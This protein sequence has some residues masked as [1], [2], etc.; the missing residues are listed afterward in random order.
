MVDF[1][2]KDEIFNDASEVQLR[3]IPL[4]S[5]TTSVLKECKSNDFNELQL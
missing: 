3:N 1:V 2:L 5:T 4:I